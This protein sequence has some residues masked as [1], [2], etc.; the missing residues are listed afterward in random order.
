MPLAAAF[1]VVCNR[2]RVDGAAE[3]R[4]AWESPRRATWPAGR[5]ESSQKP[6]LQQMPAVSCCQAAKSTAQ[7]SREFDCSAQT[8]INWVARAAG[9]VGKPLPGTYVLF[10]A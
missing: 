6:R 1:C 3:K 2:Q 10:T 5:F 4:L 9:D 7:L 8:I